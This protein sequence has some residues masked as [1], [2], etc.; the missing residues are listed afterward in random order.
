MDLMERSVSILESQ[1]KQN[2]ANFAAWM[3]PR[4]DRDAH[5][6]KPGA[7]VR[8]SVKIMPQYLLTV[9]K[10]SPS[11]R[12]HFLKVNNDKIVPSG[13]GRADPS[14]TVSSKFRLNTLP[15]SESAFQILQKFIKDLKNLSTESKP[16]KITSPDISKKSILRVK[17]QEKTPSKCMSRPVSTLGSTLPQVN[18]LTPDVSRVN[19]NVSRSKG[20]SKDSAL[21]AGSDKDS[22]YGL[23][24]LTDPRNNRLVLRRQAR[25]IQLKSIKTDEKLRENIEED[26]Y[27]FIGGIKKSQIYR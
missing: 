20:R 26:R 27:R 5:L 21:R 9:K 16:E 1:P 25:A 12:S 15:K 7:T 10:A 2:Y 23:A 17:K 18:F 11:T 8:P 14:V 13:N 3:R 19:L 6:N 24:N 22:E 4:H